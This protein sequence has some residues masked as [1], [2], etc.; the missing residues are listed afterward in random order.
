MLCARIS[1]TLCQS[2]ASAMTIHAFKSAMK[3]ANRD[4]LLKQNERKVKRKSQYERDQYIYPSTIQYKMCSFDLQTL[5]LLF[6]F[7]Y[8]FMLNALLC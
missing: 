8:R 4:S 5:L 7:I 1:F 6:E 2:I 3:V